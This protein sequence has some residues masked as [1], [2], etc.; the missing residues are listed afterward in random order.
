MLEEKLLKEKYKVIDGKCYAVYE[1]LNLKRE[2][3]A[4]EVRIELA[5][6]NLVLQE[7]KSEL[8]KQLKEIIFSLTE[9]AKI[10]GELSALGFCKKDNPVYKKI[11]GIILK[12][13]NGNPVVSK[14]THQNNCPNREV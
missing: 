8:E 1:E 2:V 6:K 7:K 9:N 12:D 3:D 10:D 14:Y 11:D 13:K 5:E 4:C